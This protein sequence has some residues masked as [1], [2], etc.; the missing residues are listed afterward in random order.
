M[1]KIFYILFAI[2]L[3]HVS[4]GAQWVQQNG[5]T[6]VTLYNIDFVDANTGWIVGTS[7]KIL[8]TT[9]GG[10]NWVTQ[11]PTLPLN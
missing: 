5:G 2:S 9:N 10:L 11:I 1:K 6:T 3:L 8:K 7:S 4:A